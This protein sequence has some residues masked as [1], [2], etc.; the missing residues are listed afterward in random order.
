[1]DATIA[2]TD[3]YDRHFNV[4][5]Y[6]FLSDTPPIPRFNP[7]TFVAPSSVLVGQ[8]Y[9]S[10]HTS[11][12]YNA[13][14]R[15]EDNAVSI[16]YQCAVQENATIHAHETDCYID[17]YTVIG[18]GA[19]IFGSHIR[20]GCLIGPGVHIGD[21]CQIGEFCVI[22]AGVVVP[23]DTVV[24][25]NSIWRTGAKS[26]EKLDHHRLED[27]QNHVPA[28][29]LWKEASKHHAEFIGHGRQW[30]HLDKI[31]TKVRTQIE[32]AQKA[33]QAKPQKNL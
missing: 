27:L 8:V 20:T 7:D 12:W 3:L 17:P 1:M 9:L 28:V 33:R 18:Y 15:G 5:R 14:L 22:E 25:D 21:G 10:S 16:G 23:A 29:D 32:D 30:I 24:P 11:I 2:H 26:P 19:T 13:V 6:P 31:L 4:V